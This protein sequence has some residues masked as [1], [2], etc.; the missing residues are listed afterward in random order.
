MLRL[1]RDEKFNGYVVRRLL[2][3]RPGLE[4]VRVWHGQCSNEGLRVAAQ[5]R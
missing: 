5:Q 1:L 3:R 4:L 2:R